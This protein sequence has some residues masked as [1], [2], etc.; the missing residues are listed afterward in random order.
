MPLTIESLEV[1]ITHDSANAVKGINALVRALRRLKTAAGMGEDLS[2]VAKGIRAIARASGALTAGKISKSLDGVKKS[3]NEVKESVEGM[4]KSLSMKEISDNAHKGIKK[5]AD[6]WDVLLKKSR[7]GVAE[8]E[9]KQILERQMRDA[10]NAVNSSAS[11]ID[12]NNRYA[13]PL[14]DRRYTDQSGYW[15]DWK[16]HLDSFKTAKQLAAE[17]KEQAKQQKAEEKAITEE[18]NRRHKIEDQ[19]VK[20]YEK[21]QAAAAKAEAREKAI[22]EKVNAK[23]RILNQKY[24]ANLK[25]ESGMSKTSEVGEMSDQMSALVSVFSKGAAIAMKVGGKILDAV[26]TPI[27][28]AISGYKRLTSMVKRMILRRI[29]MA[30]L[31]TITDGFKTGLENL[32]QYSY[33][34]NGLDSSHAYQGLDAL[35]TAAMYVKNSVGAAAMP[36]INMFIPVLQRLASWAAIAANAINQLVSA[37]SGGDT[38]TKAKEYAVDYMDGVKNSANGAGKA[39]KDLKATLLGFDEINRLDSAD[40]GSGS[41]GGGGGSAKLDY[42]SMFEEAKIDQ[43]FKDFTDQVKQKIEAGDWTGVGELI[44]DKLNTAVNKINTKDIGKAITTKISNGVKLVAGFLK[45]TNFKNIG[46]KIQDFIDGAIEG[47]DAEAFADAASG[48]ITGAIDL[49]IG[50]VEEA[51]NNGTAKK[52][53]EKFHDFFKKVLENLTSYLKKENWVEVGAKLALTLSEFFEGA[54]FPELVDT[55][56]TFLSEAMAAAAQFS[57]A[58]QT[59]LVYKLLENLAGKPSDYDSFA[60]WLMSGI[61]VAVTKWIQFKV[62][63]LGKVGGAFIRGVFGGAS[64]QI[65][66]EI[67]NFLDA[68]EKT[69]KGRIPFLGTIA[70]MIKENLVPALESAKEKTGDW[71]GVQELLNEALDPTYSAGVK[72]SKYAVDTYKEIQ[73]AAQK[74]AGAIGGINNQQFTDVQKRIQELNKALNSLG[75]KRNISFTVQKVNGQYATGNYGQG[76]M[77]ASGGFP[78]KGELF[79]AGEESPELVGTLNG[80]TAVVSGGEISG[81]SAA[82]YA[83]GEREVAAINNLIRALNQKD[84]TAVVSTDSIVSGLA[85]KNRRDGVST[86]PVSV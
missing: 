34:M 63:L 58:V 66:T 14:S 50:F 9:T 7:P 79:W 27:K 25:K 21:Q 28:R 4:N 62:G 16:S 55:L 12:W 1:K 10:Q 46:A 45:K 22:Q 51:H 13:D 31:R 74:A 72:Y 30:A 83:T 61:V 68:V 80:R 36:V 18:A 44:A 20:D 5:V 38:Y 70:R 84:M 35:A 64:E 75:Q 71:L 52:L 56:S 57:I 69:S 73:Q 39:A 40:K 85:R 37:F 8:W 78:S 19:I 54:N 24:F 86:V 77:Y 53:G 41:G 6:H 49:F 23:A 17:A 11:K 15:D 29:I 60:S 47:I 33:A 76:T 48:V 26:V 67:I 32:Y 3:A 59:M 43:A 42:S 65:L 81:I 2:T 82:V